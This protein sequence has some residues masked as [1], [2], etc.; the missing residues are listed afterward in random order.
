MNHYPLWK[1]MLIGAV[2]A[3]C[4]L[5]A[6][7]NLFGEDPAVQISPAY[8]RNEKVDVNLQNTVEAELMTRL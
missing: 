2:I 5:Y 6:L 3:L 1:Y 4:T 8:A 7:P